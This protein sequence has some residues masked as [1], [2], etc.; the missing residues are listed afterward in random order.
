MA[1]DDVGRIV[2][3]FK[4]LANLTIYK[5][6]DAMVLEDTCMYTHTRSLTYACAH[7]YTQHTHSIIK[8]K[9]AGWYQCVQ[10]RMECVQNW[11]QVF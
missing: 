6:Q 11:D 8:L 10:N 4:I 3:K 5:K 2:C 1:T 9:Q 7:A